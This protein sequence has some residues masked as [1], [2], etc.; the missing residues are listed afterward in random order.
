[1]PTVRVDRGLC[2]GYANCVFNADD[3][4]DL[5]EDDLV[6]VLQQTIDE[7]DR[8]RVTAAAESCPVA[9]LTVEEA[10]DGDG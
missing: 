9:A 3:V 1:M 7:S 2:E 4:F 8:A 6:V 5:D 10:T